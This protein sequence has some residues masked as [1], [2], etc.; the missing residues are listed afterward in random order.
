MNKSRR[1]IMRLINIKKCTRLVIGIM[2]TVVFCAACSSHTVPLKVTGPESFAGSGNFGGET[3]V[4]TVTTTNSILAIDAKGRRV[5]L[6]D[7]GTGAIRQYKAAP[8]VVLFDQLKVGDVV[9]ATV[10]ERMSLFQRAKSASQH[11]DDTA[12]VVRSAEAKGSSV[13]GVETEDFTATILDMN[14]YSSQVTLQGVDGITRT[15]QVGEYVNLA[16]F[17]VGDQ[18]KVR[19]TEAVAIDIQKL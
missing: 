8:Q 5:T 14:Y 13:L 3:V 19:I 1:K 12:L 16:D 11:F 18:I 9:K 6:K 7:L 17:S 10:V 15:I 2:G 4:R